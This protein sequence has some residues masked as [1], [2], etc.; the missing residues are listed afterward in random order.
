M[1]IQKFFNI[2][3]L[4]DP[5]PMILITVTTVDFDNFDEWMPFIEWNNEFQETYPMKTTFLAPEIN[6]KQ[7]IE[8]LTLHGYTLN[9]N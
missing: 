8:T 7:I 4:S 3:S 6:R 1:G 2:S 5:S 9:F